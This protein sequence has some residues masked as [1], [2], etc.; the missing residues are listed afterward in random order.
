MRIRNIQNLIYENLSVFWVKK[1]FKFFDADPGKNIPEPQQCFFIFLEW[2][3][4]AR[5]ASGPEHK[6]EDTVDVRNRAGHDGAS[7]M[8]AQ[9]WYIILVWDFELACFSVP[10]KWPSCTSS[11]YF[12][13]LIFNCTRFTLRN[14]FSY[15]VAKYCIEHK[16]KKMII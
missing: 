6:L 16:N 15:T 11:K 10:K 7:S 4:S 8:I 14:R 3:G 13:E 9:Y 12:T 5:I 1:I 2:I